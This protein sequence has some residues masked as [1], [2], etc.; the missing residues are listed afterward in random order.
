[1]QNWF[2]TGKRRRY[3]CQDET[4]VGLKSDTGRVITAPKVKP[5]APVQW[6]REN[7]WIY[8][9]VEPETGWHFEQ[10]YDHL[11]STHF[12]SF[13][14]GLS[15]ALGDDIAVIQ[16][17]Q[18]KADQALALRWS[19]NLIPI[20][21]PAHS[22]ELNPIERFWQ[23]IKQQTKGEN[24]KTLSELRTRLRQVLEELT[25]EQVASLTGYNF[26]LEALF[27]AAS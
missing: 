22:P 23:W 1:M 17:G 27:Y 14:D 8:G 7:F 10:E 16:L 12:Q 15:E 4:R 6:D 19:E 18:A 9:V 13:L 5:T 20:F 2:G 25:A 24:F 26:I 3:L 11:N 21:Q